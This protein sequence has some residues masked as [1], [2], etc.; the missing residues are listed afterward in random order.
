MQKP[1]MQGNHTGVNPNLFI[2]VKAFYVNIKRNLLLI[3]AGFFSLPSLQDS[4]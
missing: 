4:I 1:A 2:I 3:N